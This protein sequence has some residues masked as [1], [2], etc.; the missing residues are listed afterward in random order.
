M[1]TS[2]CG[3][4]VRDDQWR[5]SLTRL[6]RPR[7]TRTAQTPPQQ[8][9]AKPWHADATADVAPWWEAPFES[10]SARSPRGQMQ[11]AEQQRARAQSS[12]DA[13]RLQSIRQG[14]STRR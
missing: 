12:E 8:P 1:E 4:P 5:D 2:S 10:D 6:R 9:D 14:A 7:S 3:K 13:Q 11:Y